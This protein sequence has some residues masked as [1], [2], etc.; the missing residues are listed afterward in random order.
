MDTD[1]NKFESRSEKYKERIQTRREEGYSTSEALF[2]EYYLSTHIGWI[3]DS[4][5]IA[6][7]YLNCRIKLAKN[8]I[9]AI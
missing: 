2:W 9:F 3:C 5:L 4:I 8:Q 6:E 7:R 1:N